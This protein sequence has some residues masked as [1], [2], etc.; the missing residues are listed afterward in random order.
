MKKKLKLLIS[1]FL[2]F[3]KISPVT[4]GGGF[5]MIPILEVE[6]VEK[7]KWIDRER[8]VDIFAVSQS[9]PGAVA[10]NSAT[11]LGYDI[12]GVP[13][14]VAALL[15]I[16]I[17]TFIIIII[18]A[19]LFGSVQSNRY[20]YAALKGI[21]PVIIALI[22]MAAYKMG[23]VS[24]VDFKC[25]GICIIG[26]IVLLLFKDLN[27]IFIIISGAFAGIIAVNIGTVLKK[28][29]AFPGKKNSI[30]NREREGS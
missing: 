10:V 12:A 24:L 1:I 11:Y 22:A 6:M 20:V 30:E 29:H 8:I 7:K 15:G 2:T 14:A 25:W 3:C 21:K 5:A 16:V 23:R 13:G 4:F 17:P 18:L 26:F 19:M 27:I 9:I 28:V